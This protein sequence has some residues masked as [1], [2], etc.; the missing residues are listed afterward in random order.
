MEVPHGSVISACFE[1]GLSALPFDPTTSND[2]LHF[3]GPLVTEG[4]SME[5]TAGNCKRQRTSLPPVQK[6]KPESQLLRLTGVMIKGAALLPPSLAPGLKNGKSFS[7][8]V[9]PGKE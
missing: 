9:H 7:V 6:T 1:C 2:P 5:N 3:S 8:K 4:A